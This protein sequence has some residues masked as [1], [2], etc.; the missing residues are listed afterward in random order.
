MKK[1][2]F[3]F[4]TLSFF[5]FSCNNETDNLKKEVDNLQ[6]IISLQNAYTTKKSIISVESANID[7]TDCWQI[8]FSD[9]TTLKLPKDIVESIVL[10][11]TSEIYTIL[12][13][14]DQQ[15]VFYTKE[16]ILP[17]GL[18]VLTKEVKFMKNTEIAI[19]FRVNPSNAIFNY[20]EIGRAHV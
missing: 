12:L 8:T 6:S 3:I 19:E 2:I 15:Y 17:T 13:K 7:K 14:N 4:T 5:I 10:N 16:T 9:N 1:V 20:D 11:E 18:A